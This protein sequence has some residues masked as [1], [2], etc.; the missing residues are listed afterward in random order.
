MNTIGIIPARYESSRFPGKPLALIAGKTMI[1]HVYTRAA[2][3][4][5]ELW[6]ATDHPDIYRKVYEFGGRAIMTQEEHQNGTSRCLEAFRQIGKKATVILNIQ[7]D[8][9]LLHPEDLTRLSG[10]FADKAVTI[11]T[12]ALPVSPQEVLA[13]NQ[14]VFVTLTQD[15]RALYFS[16]SL[17][18]AVRDVPLSQWAS[19]HTFY[20]HLGLY[21]YRPESLA[22][23]CKLPESSLE[24]AEKLEQNRWLEHGGS[25][26]VGLARQASIPVDYPEDIKKVEAFLQANSSG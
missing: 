8:E 14:G 6:V 7:G 25:I 11:G 21:A 5:D 12:L 16:R 10:L 4:V 19:T 24:K 18:P 17:I 1:E 13:H 3:A 2:Q 22:T 26:K 20:R 9:P 23:F 15:N